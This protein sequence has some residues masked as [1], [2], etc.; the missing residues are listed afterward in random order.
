MFLTDCFTS[1]KMAAKAMEIKPLIR[2]TRKSL[3]TGLL[4]KNLH[5]LGKFW[6]WSLVGLFRSPSGD[7]LLQETPQ[8]WLPAKKKSI[9][10][11]IY[12]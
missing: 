2:I 11:K 7:I 12:H 4:A 5:G 6:L 9:I 8:G 3:K 1:M 10:V